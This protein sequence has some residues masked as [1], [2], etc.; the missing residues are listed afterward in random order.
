[1]KYIKSVLLLTLV[2]STP[3]AARAQTQ[4]E[5]ALPSL[6]IFGFPL[7]S[8]PENEKFDHP[9]SAQEFESFL[10]EVNR[11]A[12]EQT[13]TEMQ[14]KKTRASFIIPL[15]FYRSRYLFKPQVWTEAN[16]K[17]GQLI[18][19][20]FARLVERPELE[21]KATDQASFGRG[22]QDLRDW[23]A[24]LTQDNET[25][26]AMIF[27]MD[28]GPFFGQQVDERRFN[29]WKRL[30]SSAIPGTR[31]K[32]VLMT[33]NRA[34]EPM[35]IG[36]MNADNSLLWARRYSNDSGNLSNA[37]LSQASVKRVEDYGF[38]VNMS[39]GGE[40]SRVY[41]DEKLGLRFYY[42]SW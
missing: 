11:V 42:V 35:I 18:S 33:D 7:P 31:A 24:N 22:L 6:S 8:S 41:L 14:R 10:A 36:V 30:Q 13:I 12:Q 21:I 5:L 17:E 3:L 34:P 32:F 15:A 29:S 20:F 40:S 28:D 26:G 2:I 27:T 19:N 16:I 39:S 1:M 38:Q 9:Y 4:T 23:F 37:N 25:L